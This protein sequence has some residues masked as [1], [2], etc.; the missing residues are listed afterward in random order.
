MFHL[1]RVF[2]VIVT[3]AILS[4]LTYPSFA[5]TTEGANLA[6]QVDDALMMDAKAYASVMGVD[7][8]EAI[9]RL[10]LQGDIGELNRELTE[11]EGE[12]FAGLWIQH[13]PEYRVIVMFTR[14]SE[15]ILQ[16]YVRDRALAGLV[17]AHTTHTTLKELETARSQAVQTVSNLG[18]RVSS[19]INIPNNRAELYVLDPAQL[20]ESL[21]KTNTRLPD[22]VDVVKFTELSRDVAD[23]FG[24]KALTTCTS[25][26][27]VR[28]SS[29]TKGV[30]TAGHCNNSQSYSGV[31]LPFMSGTTGGVYDIQW[32]RG[33]HA[34]TVRNLIWD[35][36]YN[37][38]IY[39]VK[40]R[41][42]QSVGEWVCK[43]GMT[44]GYACG[45]IATT[46]QDGV[47][48]RVDNMT[49]QGGDSGGPWFWNNTA[50]GTTIAACTLGNG[51]PCTIYGPVD[52]I[53][54]I[55]GLTILTN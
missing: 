30:T 44:T 43:Y 2:A 19:A 5:Q 54:N 12:T 13:Q 50:Y 17:E 21:R 7:T 46:S 26:F 38:F 14:D 16:S 49:V 35:G 9:R 11:E 23:I 28:N 29:G 39:S 6:E 37:R 36:T 10:Q 1:R 25:G 34:F 52:H 48:I 40:F 55:L 18:I 32:H 4:V 31:S 3:L 20:T 53:Y 22:N 33:D 27:S 51:T 47:N 45:T 41:A 24:G 15:T 42:S 8:D